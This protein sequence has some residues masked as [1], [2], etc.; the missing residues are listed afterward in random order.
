LR[1]RHE[2]AAADTDWKKPSKVKLWDTGDWK[3]RGALD[4]PGEILS[5]AYSPKGDWLAVGSWD[6][7]VRVFAIK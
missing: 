4:V 7:T 6:K 1:S 2:L 5:I 3:E